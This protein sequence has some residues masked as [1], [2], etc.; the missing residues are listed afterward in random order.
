MNKQCSAVV[1]QET[2]SNTRLDYI[3]YSNCLPVAFTHAQPKSSLVN[4]LINQ[5]QYCSAKLKF[6]RKADLGLQVL[7]LKS[8]LICDQVSKVSTRCCFKSSKS[9]IHSQ[10]SVIYRTKSKS[11]VECYD[12]V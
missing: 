12:E 10:G 6:L 11:R 5:L 7:L 2:I 9:H 8:Y 3:K 1:K 4:C